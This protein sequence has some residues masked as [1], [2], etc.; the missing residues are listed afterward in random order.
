MA[1]KNKKFEFRIS[2]EFFEEMES[3]K[4]RHNINWSSKIRAF[5][6]SEIKNDTNSIQ[7]VVENRKSKIN[8]LLDGRLQIED[9]FDIRYNESNIKSCEFIQGEIPGYGVSFAV[10]FPLKNAVMSSS[11]FDDEDYLV[12]HEPEI[13][14][15]DL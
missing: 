11:G 6:E 7:E 13:D 1:S 2:D 12:N 3:Y 4:N 8:P 15:E 14:D 10:I 9:I 5:I